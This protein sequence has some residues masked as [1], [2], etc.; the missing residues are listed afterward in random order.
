M[1]KLI[2][3][4]IMG[5]INENFR[6]GNI[7]LEDAAKLK[8]YT[9]K[10]YDHLYSDYDEMEDFEDMTDESFMTEIDIICK[11]RDEALAAKDKEIAEKDSEIAFLKKQLESLK[12]NS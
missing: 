5:S 8:H 3:N 2:Q 10:L 4:D 6:V 11:E 7:T 12:T 9:Q 1:K